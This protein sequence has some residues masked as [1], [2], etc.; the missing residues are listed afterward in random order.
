[1]IVWGISYPDDA[2]VQLYRGGRLVAD[3]P[4]SGEVF[5]GQTWTWPLWSAYYQSQGFE[6]SRNWS[7][8]DISGDH[9]PTLLQDDPQPFV[10]VDPAPAESKSV[11]ALNPKDGIVYT[12]SA[13]GD[14]HDAIADFGY[15]PVRPNGTYYIVQTIDRGYVMDGAPLNVYILGVWYEGQKELLSPYWADGTIVRPSDEI[16]SL[17]V[18]PMPDDVKANEVGAGISASAVLIGGAVAF[19]AWKFLKKPKARA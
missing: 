3:L 17:P 9:G 18:V 13:V 8:A 10:S 14:L 4:V 12:F 6:T 7:D 11:E 19:V 2:R 15:V 16:I 5:S 1:M